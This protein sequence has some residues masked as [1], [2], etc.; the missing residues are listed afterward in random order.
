MNTHEREPLCRRDF[1]EI[2]GIMM[3][4][5]RYCGK[6]A[7]SVFFPTRA[8]NQLLMQ[9]S[10]SETEIVPFSSSVASFSSCIP[11]TGKYKI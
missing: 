11:P 5:L 8:R 4:E 9:R 6:S 10:E 3:I 7:V 2:L 1:E